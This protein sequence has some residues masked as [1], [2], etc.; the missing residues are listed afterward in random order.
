MSAQAVAVQPGAPSASTQAQWAVTDALAITKR[1]LL[2]YVRVPTLLV[3][4]TIQPVM[5]VVLFRYV[6]GGAIRLPA[7]LS[8]VDFLMPGIFVQT[9][10][11]GS[12]QTGVGLAED[13]AGGMIERFRS[14]PMARSAVLAGRTLSDTVRNV[15]VV[16]LMT[17]VGMA[18][19]F[20][21]HGGFPGAVAGLLFAVLFGLAFSW[22]MALIGLTAGNVEA[23]QASSFVW[24]FPFVFASTAFVP[25]QSMPGWL[26]AWAKV[27]PVSIVVDAIRSLT[28]GGRIAHEANL[29]STS[30]HVWQ[31]LAWIVG[32]L[33][34]FVPLAVRRYR[35]AA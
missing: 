11:F 23:A 35:R 1:N 16:V 29:G 6:F 19:G 12:T 2:K 3:F 14:L 25:L 7:G 33:V 15:F 20:R 13:L 22:I 31:A 21:V 18:V 30:T 27:N 17:G 28:L 4:S 9:V 26:Q 8:Y 5:F 10:V 34:V 24:V 32:I